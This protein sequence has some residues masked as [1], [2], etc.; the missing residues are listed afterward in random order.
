MFPLQTRT[1][2]LGATLLAA[3]SLSCQ[4]VITVDLNQAN[5]QLV[6]EAIVTD[7]P[8]PYAVTLSK[9]GDYFTPS[10]YFPP[11]TH[12]FVTIA[13]NL[14]V[15]DTL[16]ETSGG[17]YHTSVLHGGPGRTYYLR[18]VAQGKEYDA[19]STMPPKVSIDTLLAIRARESDGD[20]IYNLY[21]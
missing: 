4:K 1:S 18:V 20:Q 7:G 15:S 11:V 17:S 14:G 9:S 19:V 2:W 3:A 21:V 8:G 16:K 5:P 12:A 13:D 10:L 6:A